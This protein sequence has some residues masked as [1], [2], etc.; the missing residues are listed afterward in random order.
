MTIEQIIEIPPSH[1]LEFF[2]PLDLP[3]GRARVE[4]KVT[5]EKNESV[6]KGKSA[7]GCLR[8]FANPAKISGEETAWQRAVIE[9]HAKN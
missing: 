4:L 3:V 7:F 2:L 5:P 8:R 6:T 9:K 1:R